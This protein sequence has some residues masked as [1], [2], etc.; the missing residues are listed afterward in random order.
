MKKLL[1]SIILAACLA[2]V[3]ACTR[4][5]D[6][7]DEIALEIGDR[8][9]TVKQLNRDIRFL[10]A[11][12]VDPES[13]SVTLEGPTLECVVNYY[14]IEGYAKEHGIFV[15][16][17]ELLRAVHEIQKD[18]P[19]RSF[20]QTLLRRYVRLEQW[21]DALK[22]ELMRKKVFDAVTRHVRPPSYTQIDQ[23]YREHIDN[24]KR[25]ARVRFRQIVTYSEDKAKEALS[26]IKK[27]ESIAEVA[28]LYSYGPEAKKGGEVGWIEKGQLDPS[29]DKVLFSLP[30]G[31]ISSI[32]KSPY[33]FHIFQVI[34]TDPG[35][36]SPLK[37]V[38]PTIEA[39]LYRQ[40][41]QKAFEKWLEQ[42]RAQIKIRVIKKTLERVPQTK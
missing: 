16:K 10:S 13:Q 38:A 41:R 21:E 33:G 36:L 26:R 32:I 34:E 5:I 8:K 9:V 28:R 14:L 18:Y 22:R 37:E 35:G 7:G 25:P 20:S 29:M 39:H 6:P 1:A 27:G 19:D 31:K 24:F 23:Y 12:L 3:C 42:Q 11:D 2:I 40:A 15:S 4:G 30:V 17:P